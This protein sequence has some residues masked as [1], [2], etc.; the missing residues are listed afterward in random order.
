MSLSRRRF[1]ALSSLGASACFADFDLGRRDGGGVIFDAPGGSIEIT[2]LRARMLDLFAS[3]NG[4]Q[5]EVD[6]QGP[7]L[8]EPLAVNAPGPT[9][10][11]VVI[12]SGS[13]LINATLATT[14]AAA[15]GELALR[16]EGRFRPDDGG[17]TRDLRLS[18]DDPLLLTAERN[19]STMYDAAVQIDVAERLRPVHWFPNINVTN[20]ETDASGWIEL[21]STQN[22][23]VYGQLVDALTRWAREWLDP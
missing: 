22:A 16:L 6:V 9:P 17:P 10:P 4:D 7:W 13:R 5:L 1:L 15:A 8:L 11:Q 2:V 23:V 18:V 20:L 3:E 14:L 12:P 21:T 19:G